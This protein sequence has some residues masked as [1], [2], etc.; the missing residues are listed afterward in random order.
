M[1]LKL[2]I[3]NIVLAILLGASVFAYSQEVPDSLA[4]GAIVKLYECKATSATKVS[5]VVPGAL[6][7]TY[8]SEYLGVAIWRSSYAFVPNQ[9]T[10]YYLEISAY[11]F[12]KAKSTYIFK[13]Q[14]HEASEFYLNGKKMA[15]KNGYS[16]LTEVDVEVELPKGFHRVLLKAY[17]NNRSSEREISLAWNGGTNNAES[18][19]WIPTNQVFSNK[20]ALEAADKIELEYITDKYMEK[21]NEGPSA[22]NSVHPSYTLTNLFSDAEFAPRVGG[23]DFFSNGDLA[24]C[25]WDSLGS[26]YVLKNAA[27]A[28][29]FPELKPIRVAWGLSE[30]L[31]LKVVND[32]IYVLQKHELTRL[33]DTDGDGL[34]DEYTT[35]CNKWGAIGNF[36]EFAFGLV[37]KEGYFYA[38]LSIAINP[39]GKSTIPQNKDRGKCVKMGLDG[40]IEAIASGLR[41]PN[42]IGLGVDDAIFVADNQGDW[43][44]ACKILHIQ[45]DDFFG[46]YS[47]DLY[48]VGKLLEK[49]PVVWLPQGEIGNSASQ[50]G[51]MIDQGPFRGQMIHGDVTHGG[52]KRVFV[53]KIDG[54]YQGIV[55][56][57]C[58]GFSAGVNRFAWGPDTALYVGGVGSTG[59][60]GQF[61]KNWYGL[62]KIKYNGKST[63]ELLAVRSMENGFELEFTE[64]V[65]PK[66]ASSAASYTLEQW[67]YVPTMAYGG[68]KVD[69]QAVPILSVSVSPEGKKVFLETSNHKISYVVAIDAAGVRSKFGKEPWVSKGWYTLNA[70]GNAKGKVTGAKLATTTK[71][72]AA[73]KPA[74]ATPPKEPSDKEVLALGDKL[75]DKSGCYQC[76]HM[77]NQVLGPSFKMVNKKYSNDPA[78]L[79]KLV[80]K[81]YKGG[82]GVWGEQAMGA[83][84]HLDK[85]DIKLLVRWILLQPE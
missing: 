47:V 80:E 67:R 64:P 30:P 79:A 16:A 39:G 81:V 15:E 41:T 35:I 20:K 17:N 29:A 11:I 33:D 40:S 3:S 25:T 51:L 75:A 46:S 85:S 56:P 54:N 27:K 57:F 78:T 6:A 36:H 61:G 63:F 44:P 21:V 72:A 62:Q 83:N 7:K 13:L 42:G 23:M 65:D 22:K 19:D 49:P 43:L 58:Q 55:F 10:P 76:H 8:Q 12:V 28:K 70:I 4:K 71:P 48:N 69:K 5:E 53:E 32:K 14:S 84:T 31:G 37:Y 73:P 82:S 68:P 2:S 45:K 50:P 66:T 77:T 52:L 24:I 1:K 34:V 18:F 60:W 74:G 9:G 38:T 59:N 26:V